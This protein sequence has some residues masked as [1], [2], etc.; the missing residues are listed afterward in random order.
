MRLIVALLLLITCRASAQE[1]AA[2]QR[3]TPALWQEH[4]AI[5]TRRVSWLLT[6][7]TLRTA[8]FESVGG[9]GSNGEDDG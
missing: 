9:A 8:V 1:L 5:S 4:D 6:V 7:R 3:R 2:L